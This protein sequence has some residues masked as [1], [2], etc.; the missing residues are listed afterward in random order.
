M[1]LLDRHDEAKKMIAQVLLVSSFV[2]SLTQYSSIFLDMHRAHING[3]TLVIHLSRLRHSI[4]VFALGY[5]GK[6]RIP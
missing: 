6:K 1:F 3:K 4:V 2:F 5:S